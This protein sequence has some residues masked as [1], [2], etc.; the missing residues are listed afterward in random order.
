MVQG[1]KLR[2]AQRVALLMLVIGALAAAFPRGV[3]QSFPPPA[4]A[5]NE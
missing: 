1:E 3:V 5:G 4:G 2:D